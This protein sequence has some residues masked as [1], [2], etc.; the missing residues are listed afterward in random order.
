MALGR[1]ADGRRRA[2]GVTRRS[3]ARVAAAS[4]AVLLVVTFVATASARMN[5][6]EAERYERVMQSLRSRVYTFY[7]WYHS[8]GQL[9]LHVTNLGFFG[10][11]GADLDAPSAEWPAGS[12]NEYLYAAGLWVGGKIDV[13]RG[14]ELART[15]TLVSAGVYQ[16]EFR[17]SPDDPLQ[18]IYESWEGAAN[19][20]RYVDDDGDCNDP[21][22]PPF[23]PDN[24]FRGFDEDPYDGVDNDDDGRVDEDFAAIS[25]QMF[26]MIYEDTY[27]E[28]VNEGASI[29]LHNSIGLKVIQQ[30]YQWTS[31]STDDFVGIDYQ[32]VNVGSDTLKMAYVGFMVDADVGVDEDNAYPY[33]DDRGGFIDTLIVTPNPNNPALSDTLSISLCYMYDDPY[34]SDGDEASGYF[35]CMFL[36]HPVGEPVAPGDTTFPDAPTEVRVHAFRIWSSG[37]EDPRNDQQ[38]Y[39]FL[40]G[41]IPAN[42]GPS[43]S[44]DFPMLDGY[45]NDNDGQIDEEDEWRVNIDREADS[46]L[47]W[48]LL[49]SAGPFREIL[50]GDT[51]AFQYAFVVGEGLEG[52]I[53]NAATAQQI[54]NGITQEIPNCIGDPDSVKLNWVADTPPPPPEQEFTV[55]DRFVRIEWDDYPETV[56]DPLTRVRDFYGY[57]VWKTV[58][59][60]RISQEPRDQ[61][62][63]LILDIDRSDDGYELGLYD[64]GLE[65]VGKYSFVDTL[66]KNGFVYWYAVTAYDSTGEGYH[67]GKYSQ[68]KTLVEVHSGVTDRLNEVIVVPNPYIDNDYMARWNLE[69]TDA[70]PMGEYIYWQ[71]LP[72]NSIVRIYSLGGELVATLQPD[73][74]LLGGDARWDM[75]SRN[76]QIVVSGVY[77][78]HVDSPV[79]EKIGKFVLIR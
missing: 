76:D 78:Y 30:S 65:G 11:F 38:R 73:P 9:L 44:A 7:G 67:F 37:T 34:G 10:R 28:D 18:T 27:E 3:L 5:D 47:D 71:N 15:D 75:I 77:L 56:E 36:G 14:G 2:T 8:V 50:P 32:V 45:D 13:W 55:G 24:P 69:P 66:V 23:D 39:Q 16:L 40:R 20:G 60:R 52:M 62:W 6:E 21:S 72:E 68:N 29:D 31:E 63:E 35:G 25:Q 49:L 33:L 17:P 46:P 57:Q 48:R 41:P 74:A 4:L 58:G 61:D 51:L 59:W 12:N 64:T 70:D 26:S 53:E 42:A 43:Y 54:Y 1:T 19:S 79:G 22:G